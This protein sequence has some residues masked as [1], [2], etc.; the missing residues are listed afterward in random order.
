MQNFSLVVT[1]GFNFKLNKTIL[2][3]KNFSFLFTNFKFE[4]D[5]SIT[6]TPKLLFTPNRFLK[7]RLVPLCDSSDGVACFRLQ[8][9]APTSRD[10]SHKTNYVILEIQK[11]YRLLYLFF[12]HVSSSYIFPY[13]IPLKLI[14]SAYTFLFL[15]STR[16]GLNV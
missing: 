1:L 13:D 9:S 12:L 14:I 2:N 3:V 7:N 8:N 6:N 10:C 5:A 11:T 15:L 16:W 4:I